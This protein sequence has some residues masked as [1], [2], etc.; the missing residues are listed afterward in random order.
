MIEVQ[1]AISHLQDRHVLTVPIDPR[2][3]VALEDSESG[4]GPDDGDGKEDEPEGSI[5]GLHLILTL[6]QKRRGCLPRRSAT[7]SGEPQTHS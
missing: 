1:L 4:D 5:A 3:I 6:L 2:M 7:L